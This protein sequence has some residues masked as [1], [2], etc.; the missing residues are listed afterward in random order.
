MSGE[1]NLTVADM[2]AL[3]ES[4]GIALRAQAVPLQTLRQ[5][6]R[7][8]RYFLDWC[9]A[10]GATADLSDPE[11]VRL[12][13]G[14]LLDKGQAEGSLNVRLAAI[15]S[16]ARWL[17][18]EGEVTGTAIDR[19]GWAKLGERVPRYLTPEQRDA[20]LRACEGS[21]FLDV[22]DAALFATMFD[23]LVRSDEACS[24]TTDGVDLKA[25][26]IRV[27][28]GKGGKE[29]YSAVSA[30]TV[31]KL[32]RYQ[33]QRRRHRFA[34]IPA[35]WISQKGGLKY[36]GLYGAFKKRCAIAGIDAHPHMLRA[37]GAVQWRRDGGTT[38]GLMTIAG[39]TSIQMVMLYT[40]AAD[41]ELA[42]AEAKR[43]QDA[44]QRRRR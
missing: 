32:D 34:E 8:G 21:H 3:L 44:R 18:K 26:V 10:H 9:E 2:R 17:I 5:Y 24:M 13:L 33:R 42:I 27:R 15:R 30:E 31:A 38:E 39:W 36:R 22:R 6:E 35:Y 40:R 23:G 14:S 43:L 12:W 1:P 7:S 11:P 19:V 41:I 37:G 28:R 29:R 20:I 16:W 25:R 4:W